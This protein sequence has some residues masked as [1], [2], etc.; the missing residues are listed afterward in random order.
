M[1]TTVPLSALATC[2]EDIY[3]PLTTKYLYPQNDRR[4]HR[5]ME[6]LWGL[7]IHAFNPAHERSILHIRKSLDVPFPSG[8]GSWT[9]VPTEE[10]LAAMASLQKH[11]MTV[12]IYGRKSFL[13]EFPAAEYE[14]IFVPLDTDVDFYVLLPGQ[15]P[16][17]FSA[18]YCDFPLVTSSAN[19]FFVTFDS[20]LKIEPFDPQFSEAW[21]RLF[22]DI[23][24]LWS[25]GALPKDF[26]MSSSG[27]P[28][29]LISESGDGSESDVPLI[30][31]ESKSGSDETIMT[32][33]D[34]EL[35]SL[36]ALDRETMTTT[37]PLC[38]LATCL[39]DIEAPL[40]M[41]YLF[42][43]DDI[44]LHRHMEY[45]WGLN[46]HT[47]DPAHE[48]NILHIRKSMEVPFASGSW[49]LVP[50][51]ETLAAMKALQKHNM[52]VPIYQRKSF[53]IEFPA[54]E[55]EYIFVPL[56]TD[57]HF[58]I[59]QAGQAPRRFCAPYSDFPRVTSSA[60]PFFVTFKSQLKIDRFSKGWSRIFA[61][62]TRLWFGGALPE[63]FL[64]SSSGYPE[65]L[66]SESGDGSESDVPLI[67]PESKAGS[68][69][70]IMTPIEEEFSSPAAPDK[71][72]FVFNWVRRDAN[73][74]HERLV[75]PPL[76]PTPRGDRTRRVNLKDTPRWRTETQ[77]GKKHSERLLT[78]YTG[79]TTPSTE[80]PAIS[81]TTP[82]TV[83]AR[84]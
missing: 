47:I 72:T 43:E 20:Q 79:Q 25:G 24:T 21:D 29:T 3:A 33:I 2:L 22:G 83:Q 69:E 51:E 64:F 75:V 41:K 28:G 9:L 1:T 19:P 23:T 4:L 78:L 53:L 71:E 62:V 17:R 30:N 57:V 38:A 80:F 58:F 6:Y 35:P 11:N 61:D 39:E 31:P 13:T 48:R 26:L 18:P 37:V 5:H 84:S 63:D 56:H 44:R 49:T 15:A 7:N 42:P 45:L 77:R 65:T 12:P 76:P 67:N 52:A 60:N 10:T 70:T 46:I 32:P 54:A 55:Y 73:R 8:T 27:Y 36:S 16:R 34:E 59:L 81:R 14:Y 74:R 66:V 68:D 82:A 40:T 50:T